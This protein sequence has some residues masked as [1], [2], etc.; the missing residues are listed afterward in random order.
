MYT[1]KRIFLA[2]IAALSLHMAGAQN[3][4]AVNTFTPYSLYGVGDLAS[5]GFSFQRAM[6]GIGI[7]LRTNRTINY[8]NPASLSVQDTLSFMFDFGGEMQN[9]YL[10]TTDHTTA[11]NSLN[12][13]HLAMSFPVWRK[14]VL[15]LS[16]MPY[17]N[18][19]YRITEKETDPA[20]INRTGGV[21]YT[22][23]GEGG[24]NQVMMSV[25]L[26]FRGLV[27]NPILQ[28]VSIGGQAQYIFGSIDRY[29][30]VAFATAA[31]ADVTT[32]RFI[33]ADDFAFGLGVQYEQPVGAYGLTIGATYQFQNN[34]RVEQTNFAHLQTSSSYS[35][36]DTTFDTRLFIP[37]AFGL[38]VTLHRGAQWLVGLDYTFRNWT[39][40]TFDVPA[41]RTFKARPEH[42]FRAGFERTPN[43]YDIRY[44]LKRWSYRAGLYY[45]QTYLQFDNNRIT[46]YG[47]TVGVG[48]PIGNRNNALN[49]SAEV[50]RRGTTDNGLVRELYWKLTI[51]V[52]LYDIWFMQ[53]RFE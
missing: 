2:A 52:S 32:G 1:F 30:N 45:E 4:D 37:P 42:I 7:G 13:H 49:L 3:D 28:R 44:F 22:N 15:A 6:G 34:M 19:G 23:R 29:S 17:S 25:G 8:I 26:S 24:L 12:M 50:G 43:R 16:V 47:A 39:N 38:G 46:N 9:Y 33:R 36:L 11:S 21:T 10:S 14:M 20:A 53:P 18:V 51:G 41:S 48:I 31:N 27:S 5:P 35:A 40:A